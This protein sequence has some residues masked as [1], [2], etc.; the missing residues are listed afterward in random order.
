LWEEQYANV[1]AQDK[2]CLGLIKEYGK[3]TIIRTILLT[4]ASQITIEAN[5]EL[6][7]STGTPD[8]NSVT[9]RTICADMTQAGLS[10][11]EFSTQLQERKRLL[12]QEGERAT[13][14]ERGLL[15]YLTG[16]ERPRA[17]TV[18]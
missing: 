11:E 12:A 2:P 15:E 10:V 9:P 13:E 6:Q 1:A 14:Q 7:T 18:H 16:E 17:K 8:E 3:A 5:G 4:R